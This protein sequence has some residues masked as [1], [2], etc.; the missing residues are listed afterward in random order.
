MDIPVIN[1]MNIEVYEY[2][3]NDY[4]WELN[5]NSNLVYSNVEI[6]TEQLNSSNNNECGIIQTSKSDTVGVG[7]VYTFPIEEYNI[8]DAYKTKSGI[9]DNI[10]SCDPINGTIKIVNYNENVDFTPIN[11]PAKIRFNISGVTSDDLIKYSNLNG[12]KKLNL[13]ANEFNRIYL[14]SMNILY[15]EEF[16]IEL[17]DNIVTILK[18]DWID[19]ELP[20]FDRNFIPNYSSNTLIKI[21]RPD[22]N[23]K[24]I[25]F[26]DFHG[27]YHTFLRHLIR[28]RLMG[29]MDENCIL[30]NNHHLIFLG[31]IV[32]RGNFG[33][34][35]LILLF[36][37]K[38]I[39]PNNIH[40]NRGNHEEQNINKIYGFK[41]EIIKKIGFGIGNR[42]YYKLNS[43]L[44]YQHSALLI[45]NPINAKY[46][47]LAHGG[48]P[49]STY[50]GISDDIIDLLKRF[51]DTS[52]SKK[53]LNIINEFNNIILLN[54][55]IIYDDGVNSIRWS[56]F[57]G[58]PIS[59]NNPSRHK[60]GAD[61]LN[62]TNEQIEIIIRGHQ[63]GYYNTKLIRNGAIYNDFTNINSLPAYKMDFIEDNVQCYKFIHK[64]TINDTNEIIVNDELD[65]NFL[66]VLT[67]SNNTDVGRDLDR[68]SFVI[69]R[70]DDSYNDNLDA[71]VV[72]NSEEDRIIKRN[73]E[74]I[75]NPHLD[76]HDMSIIP[77]A[78]LD[79]SMNGHEEHNDISM[80]GGYYKK[81][82]KYKQ[83]YLQLKNKIIN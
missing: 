30:L 81:Y 46:A 35:L 52:P 66:K 60:I 75:L 3:L 72:K 44:L 68:D 11:T 43:T 31:D 65:N 62:K 22:I 67:I 26:G 38:R 14:D 16:I 54:I 78:V 1:K 5:M 15:N 61:I 4:P 27:S 9:T 23:Q 6:K 79:D 77:P 8:Y 49:L 32:D 17:C 56:D 69:L 55:D 63:D 2:K 39:N 59:S 25:I 47:Y 58:L 7:V 57:H 34:E 24:Y 51:D 12:S 37:L 76:D 40:L 48:L 13:P 80:S 71:C 41:N 82:L 73:R 45:K 74:I 83:K 50:E 10:R 19:S 29:I 21:L 53:I 64:I 33:Y 18:E 28:F 70:Y 42:I 36:L 20:H